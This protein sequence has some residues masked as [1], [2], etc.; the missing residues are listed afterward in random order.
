MP[1]LL[2]PGSGPLGNSVVGGRVLCQEKGK[3]REAVDTGMWALNAGIIS[4]NYT[5]QT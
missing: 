3:M 4:T 2:R 1:S 5:L